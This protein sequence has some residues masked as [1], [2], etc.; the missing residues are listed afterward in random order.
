VLPGS[1]FAAEEADP[2]A[3]D[4]PATETAPAAEPPAAPAEP[5]A[6][7]AE[8]P[9]SPDLAP[10]QPAPAPEEPAAVPDPPAAAPE[11]PAAPQA[12]RK[13]KNTQARAAASGAVAIADFAFAPAQITIDQGDSVTWTNNGPTPHSATA[14]DGS[15]D[16]GIF[17]AGQS[18]SH[19]FNEPGTYAYICTPHPQMH[20]TVVVQAAQTGGDTPTSNSDGTGGTGDSG[21]SG[22][23]GAE[24]AQTGS[25]PSLPSTGADTGALLILGGLMLLL[26]IAVH[27]R[28]RAQEPRPAGRIGW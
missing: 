23:P 14:S 15:F 18:R 24:T 26:G 1:L 20:G 19:T 21:G 7:P 17:P 2:A 9:A 11:Q 5:P 3:A 13:R 10:A 27:R 4:T 12:D 6:V 16:T 22:S 25:A 8:P 28:A